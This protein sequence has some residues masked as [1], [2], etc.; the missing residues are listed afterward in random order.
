MQELLADSQI[1]E[2]KDGKYYVHFSGWPKKYDRWVDPEYLNKQNE[3]NK[4]LMK[5]NNKSSKDKDNKPYYKSSLMSELVHSFWH[6]Y[7]RIV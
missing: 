4:A 7:S 5:M 3:M 1:L 2:E 6:F